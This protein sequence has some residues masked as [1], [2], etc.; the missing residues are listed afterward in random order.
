MVRR[1]RKA[2][3]NRRGQ[4]IDRLDFRRRDGSERAAGLVWALGFEP[5]ELQAEV[6]RGTREP[7]AGRDRGW[8][9]QRRDPPRLRDVLMQDFQPLYIQLR[10]KNAHSGR[11]AAGSRQAGREPT[12][13]HVIGHADDWN[14]LG[15]ALRRPD[16]GVT[17]RNNE[18]GLLCDESRERAQAHDHCVPLPRR[19]GSECCVPL[20]NRLFSC[21]ARR[22]RR[23]SR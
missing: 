13:D 3:Q 18:I 2:V 20:P 8:V 17:E 5:D 12:A 14:G 15:R 6:A 23:M 21:S 9:G 11:I 16:G 1:P 10:G 7:S 22:A 4:Y 19:I